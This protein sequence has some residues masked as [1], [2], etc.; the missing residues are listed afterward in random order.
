MYIVFEG[1][2]RGSQIYL[3][4]QKKLNHHLEKYFSCYPWVCWR[5]LDGILGKRERNTN[6]LLF[7][8]KSRIPILS[9]LYLVT[10]EFV[11]EPS[12]V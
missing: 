7:S 1:K 6:L 11:G 9:K 2:E 5:T 3:P 4:I 8:N 12:M 10:I